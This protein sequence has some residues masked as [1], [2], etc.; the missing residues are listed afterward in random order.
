M[1]EAMPGLTNV[2]ALL[3]ELDRSKLDDGTKKIVLDSLTD[4]TAPAPLREAASYNR[5]Q[6][7]AALA[8][9]RGAPGRAKQARLAN[10]RKKARG[11]RS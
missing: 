5:H 3:S 1:H 11:K 6:Y 10:D 4:G 9:L 7:R 2:T 8:W